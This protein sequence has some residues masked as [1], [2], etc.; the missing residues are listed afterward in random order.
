MPFNHCLSLARLN[1]KVCRIDKQVLL[2]HLIRIGSVQFF[3]G[4]K[5]RYQGDMPIKCLYYLG[6][7]KI[8]FIHYKLIY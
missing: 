7:R 2:V 8:L 6:F 5:Y 1:I 3:S 4:Q